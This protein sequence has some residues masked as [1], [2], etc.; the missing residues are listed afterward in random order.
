MLQ[1]QLDDGLMADL[2][3]GLW[4]LLRRFDGGANGAE[5]RKQMRDVEALLA[6][7][8]E[9]GVE[10]QDHD[11]QLYDATLSLQ[12]AAFQPSAGLTQESILETLKPTIYRHGVR[13]QVGEVIVGM[14]EKP[15]H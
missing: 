8:A 5:I 3:T 4:R 15:A 10:V 11:G 12:V 2:A 9:S 13:I 14:P 7:L 6:R 1:R